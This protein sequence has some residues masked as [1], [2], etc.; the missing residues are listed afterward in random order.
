MIKE[1]VNSLDKYTFELKPIEGAKNKMVLY[2]MEKYNISRDK[3]IDIVNKAITEKGPINPTVKYW[4]RDKKTLDKHERS[5]SLSN[6]IHTITSE[7][8]IIVPSGT[9][10][11]KKDEYGQ[12]IKSLD[13]EWTVDNMIRRN[14]EKSEAKKLK[15]L[16]EFEKAEIP[17]TLQNVMKTKN[18]SLSG[19][20]SLQHLP[21]S[22][23]SAHYTLTSITRVTS[24]IG[25]ILSEKLV[26]GN[27]FYRVKNDVLAEFVS[28]L[29]ASNYDNVKNVINKYKLVEPTTDNVI[30]MIIDSSKWYW[31]DRNYISFIREFIDELDG[32]QKAI[33][34]Y[35]HDMFHLYKLNREF[36]TTMVNKMAY[37]TSTITDDI[38]IIKS[39]DESIKNIVHHICAKELRG[40]GM[41]YDKFKGTQI[42]N[43]LASTTYH[44][45]AMLERYS[46]FISAFF[47]D[48]FLIP[49]NTAS[50]KE[51]VRKSISL[52]DTD[53]TCASY[54]SLINNDK[55][56]FQTDFSD[57]A[58]SSIIMMFNTETMN[59]LLRIYAS[60][61]NA[62]KEHYD[63]IKMKPEFFWDVFI[64]MN[65]S[66]H[67]INR[68]MV[69]ELIVLPEDKLEPS[70]SG[71]SLIASK[72]PIKYSEKLD[73]F[74]TWYIDMATGKVPV[75][76][77]EFVDKII[78]IEQ[79]IVETS[80][81]SPFEVLGIEKIKPMKDYSNSWDKS[82]YFYYELYI[83]TIGNKYGKIDEAPILT[84]KVPVTT[85]KKQLLDNW[86]ATLSPK[87][88]YGIRG[89]LEE[90]GKSAINIWR[91]PKGVAEAHGI[92]TELLNII[93]YKKIILNIMKPFYMLAEAAGIYV[94]EDTTFSEVY[95]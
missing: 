41:D 47:K 90:S 82:P 45:L 77:G 12:D 46:D 29:E 33:I 79:D 95:I 53:S 30:D 17:D 35:T 18:N 31:S 78:A 9:C 74:K 36:M 60:Q 63:R 44:L 52:S 54:F 86:I 13:A 87:Q 67:Y 39:A 40:K 7:D 84:V 6:Y 32:I 68:S 72:L 20:Y 1:F 65:G 59:H 56:M 85:S 92:P 26:A 80:T 2:L 51:M 34:L 16:G 58:K 15:A 75:S 42:G 43:T 73:E 38:E 37:K 25:N 27:R 61:M 83:K 64:P 11:I 91:I 21:I 69:E 8:L 89:V 81:K 3:A 71:V 24:G 66:K 10:Y 4:E 62:R 23:H 93:D 70:S 55:V 88:Q 76:I 94:Y 28:L 48:V 5:I 57:I 22:T 19:I 14:E 50:V 49:I